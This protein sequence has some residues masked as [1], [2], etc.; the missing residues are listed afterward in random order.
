ML[1]NTDIRIDACTLNHYS[2]LT[3]HPAIILQSI[4]TKHCENSFSF[5][6]NVGM[7]VVTVLKRYL[8][9][10]VQMF[11]QILY[12]YLYRDTLSNIITPS[13]FVYLSGLTYIHLYIRTYMHAFTYVCIKIHDSESRGQE[14]TA[15]TE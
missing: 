3:M 10:C 15:T 4:Y 5:H 9:G 1:F 14:E 13:K 2:S 6:L 12:S 8:T 7:A 11:I